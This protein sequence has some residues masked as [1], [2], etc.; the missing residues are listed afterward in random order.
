[1]KE[2]TC[3]FCR[4]RQA[5]LGVAATL[6]MLNFGS[7]MSLTTHTY[8]T[9]DGLA[10]DHVTSV[11]QDSRGFLWLSTVDGLSRFDGETF[12]NYDSGSGLAAP[13]VH[14][15]VE[16][17][18][19]YLICLWRGGVARY[20]PSE[21][22][23]RPFS[24]IAG[25]YAQSC[26]VLS[27]AGPDRIWMATAGGLYLIDTSGGEFE[28]Q[29]VALDN[30]SEFPPDVPIWD[31]VVDRHGTLWVATANGLV[32]RT[33][34]GIQN[35]H[36]VVPEDQPAGDV[37]SLLA[38]DVGRVWVGHDQGVTVFNP[39]NSDFPKISAPGDR[40]QPGSSQL[41]NGPGESVWFGPK[42]IGVGIVVDLFQSA[43]GQIW[44][45]RF[46][47]GLTVFDGNGF[48][49]FGQDQGM[50][51]LLPS[52]LAEDR[53]GD[54]WIGTLDGGVVRFVPTGF[55][56]FDHEDGIGYSRY[57][58][59]ATG[60]DL[61]IAVVAGD[62]IY[63]YDG[64][65]FEAFRP[66]V[67][68]GLDSGRESDN[69][70]ALRDSEQRWWLGTRFGLFRFAP[71]VRIADLET[72]EPDLVLDSSN[73]LPGDG[74][75]GLMEDSQGNVWISVQGES[76]DALVRWD[77]TKE[78]LH[79]YPLPENLSSASVSVSM[80]EDPGGDLWIGLQRG[81]ARFRDG[82]ITS[83]GREDGLTADTNVSLFLDQQGQLWILSM[84]LGVTLLADPTADRP[85]FTAFSSADRLPSTSVCC[86]TDDRWG[87]IYLGTTNGLLRV[88]PRNGHTR[89]FTTSDGLSN[90][91]VADAKRDRN[92]DLWFTSV[93]GV[94]RL[95]PI[96]AER[97]IAPSPVRITGLRI[98][99]ERYPLSEIGE[100]E[101]SGI[102]LEPWRN[103]VEIDFGSIGFPSG[104]IHQYQ[105]KLEGADDDWGDTT[106][107][108]FINFAQLRS[109][110]YRFL[111]RS[112]SPDD[113]TGGAPAS[114][115]FQ[116]L[117]PIWLR[118]WFLTVSAIV[119]VS[120][121]Y[122]IHRFRLERLV[123][124]E[125]VRTRIA[126]DLHDDLGSSLSR[127]SI[128]SEI[129][130]RE[131]HDGS[132]TAPQLMNEIANT[133]RELVQS[134]SDIVWAINPR[135]DDLG[136]LVARLRSFASDMFD[137]CGIEWDFES[138][139]EPW[140][141]KLD[142]GARRHLFLLIKEA[143]TNITKHAEA[144]TVKMRILV[145]TNSIVAEIQDDGR[146]FTLKTSRESEI[147]PQGHGLTNMNGRAE[148][149]GGSFQMDS[150]PG[151]GTRIR[152]T[153]PLT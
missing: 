82:V 88:D 43:Q 94:S 63:A 7:A 5:G 104:A 19:D 47:E 52:R 114:V 40:S 23:G 65:H 102:Q 15:I 92:G 58:T 25:D 90:I 50:P 74:V 146:G 71:K 8:T 12:V 55:A 84:G 60:E 148:A 27:P 61:S 13:V 9:E 120:T 127:I 80:I 57:A 33:P 35:V 143:I 153:I 126:T 31:V 132:P 111:V 73:G 117:P 151:R 136:S 119:L 128:L 48:Q 103:Q 3:R 45:S 6:V 87:R 30:T 130:K 67:L 41:P 20:N 16:V 66:R 95:S 10:H 108:R 118:W 68:A 59:F 14:D 86:A 39:G 101:I 124:L 62:S 139:P 37:R 32:T 64:D 142:P 96:A 107:R 150:A 24:Q 34:S 36:R 115:S 109:G 145:E 100:S 97:R 133:A 121:A 122:A 141:I 54:L 93:R 79:T 21:K 152:V 83:Y 81:V 17:G 106:Q 144:S 70:V 28:V 77:R 38:D 26:R 78:T 123:Q 135:Q 18:A 105:Y 56:S 44:M 51:H 149:A 4:I 125:R 85:A 131:I 46:K 134:T 129:A 69:P 116:I 11:Y 2:F 1:M 76:E 49:Q 138:P 98:G 137:G 42:D 89:H 75:V 140:K 110:H 22:N 113:V 29:P 99:G 53:A 91:E 72:A 147:E 112:V